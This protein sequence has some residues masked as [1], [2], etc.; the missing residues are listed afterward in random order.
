[1]DLYYQEK[2]IAKTASLYYIKN[3]NQKQISNVLHVSQAT[4]SRLLDKA[5]K[6]KIVKVSVKSISGSFT[7][8]EEEMCSKFNLTDCVIS[9]SSSKN[10]HLLH[11]Y[12]GE[13][14]AFHLETI[15]NSKDIIGISSWSETLLNAIK[16][17][18]SG[19][20]QFVEPESQHFTE[21]TNRFNNS[22]GFKNGRK[23]IKI[24]TENGGSV[25][26]F[27]VNTDEDNKFKKGDILKENNLTTKR[28]GGGV[29][30]MK[31]DEIINTRAKKDYKEDELI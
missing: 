15:I 7:N 3:L 26:G 28:P 22:L 5:I 8:L 2:L 21:M 9:K 23:Y 29:S 19:R 27:I 13:A 20:R 16:N 12:L 25:W 17:D 18:Y 1:M 31:W 10:N 11:S 6:N 4:V 14:A 24:T 30:P